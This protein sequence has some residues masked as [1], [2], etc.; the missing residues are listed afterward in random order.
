MLN[1]ERDEL[2]LCSLSGF[3][4]RITIIALHKNSAKSLLMLS[5]LYMNFL[6]LFRKDF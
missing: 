5:Y 4:D 2:A 6:R 3:Y 1:F